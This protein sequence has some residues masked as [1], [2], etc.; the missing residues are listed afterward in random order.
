[1]LRFAHSAATTLAATD[2]IGITTK[3]FTQNPSQDPNRCQVGTGQAAAA[4]LDVTTG[5][6]TVSGA[7]VYG[8]PQVRIPSWLFWGSKSIFF[9]YV[10]NVIIHAIQASLK[11]VQHYFSGLLTANRRS[12]HFRPFIRIP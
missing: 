10:I 1:M 12:D 9:I 6:Q 8:D 4:G 3:G 2:P 7:C 11:C 5:S